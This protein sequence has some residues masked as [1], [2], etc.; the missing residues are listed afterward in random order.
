MYS[1]REGIIL[2]NKP[3]GATSHDV[4]DFIRKKFKVR[5]VGH[6]G[7]LDPMAT[8]LLIILLGSFTKKSLSFS[9]LDKEYEA[10]MRLGISTDTGDKE[11]SVLKERDPGLFSEN[12]KNIDDILSCF[13]GSIMQVPPMFSAKK[14]RG[15]KLYELARRGISIKREPIPVFIKEIK[16]LSR[17]IPLV[18]IYVRCS[19]GTY[20]RQLAHDI[21]E[22]IGCGA[23]LIG[24]ER[25]AIGNFSV[26]D[27]VSAET[28]KGEEREFD[29]NILQ[30]K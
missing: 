19:K 8:G 21:G 2:V 6:A 28:L 14:V 17:D 15:K 29:E 1:D 5:K 11:G 16:I 13:R 9:E 23:H 25:V 20:I 7:T 27:A 12:I 4:V 30:P 26:R 18:K 22:K 24:L 3:E 10:I